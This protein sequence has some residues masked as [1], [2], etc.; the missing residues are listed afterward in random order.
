M[1]T[2]AARASL[3]ASAFAVV[4]A[5]ALALALAAAQ[6]VAAGYPDQPIRL[7]VPVTAGSLSDVV[8]RRIAAAAGAI[9][10]RPF[11]VDNLPGANFVRGSVACKDARGDGY[12]LCAL[13]TTSITFNPFLVDNLA[14]DPARDLKGVI[15]LGRY[16][17]GLVAS[18]TIPVNSMDALKA[19]AQSNPGKLNFGTYGP[20]SSA[21]VF[22]RFLDDRWHTDIAEVAYKGASELVLALM[23]GE[24]QMTWTALGN[25]TVNPDE[26]KGRI[27]VQ[28]SDPR[29]PQFPDVANYRQAGLGDFP[30][31][32]WL[33]LFAPATTPD[34]VVTKINGAIAKAIAAPAVTR[35]L[36]DQ[37]M[38]PE[39]TGAAEFARTIAREREATGRLIAKFNIPKMQ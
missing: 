24:I 4:L 39:V 27:L 1:R 36:I 16:T 25:W 37:G 12:T 28:G 20:A 2:P 14:Y 34:A 5:L 30:L 38:E 17:V 29:S 19:Y 15:M 6:P 23:K 26:S 3:S 11:V 35:F 33:G 10:G 21:N 32:T 22:R 7:I 18:P 13:P 9:I 8:S 31:S